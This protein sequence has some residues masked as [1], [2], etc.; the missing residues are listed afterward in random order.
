M[1]PVLK[2]SQVGGQA[3]RDPQGSPEHR[4]SEQSD[5]PSLPTAVRQV[6]GQSGL[7]SRAMN[8]G[9]MPARLELTT[10]GAGA[11]SNHPQVKQGYVIQDNGGL[12]INMAQGDQDLVWD[13]DLDSNGSTTSTP[14]YK[15]GR[16]DSVTSHDAVMALQR[17]ASKFVWNS[18]VTPSIQVLAD[19]RLSHW[20]ADR[21]CIIE[22]KLWDFKKWLSAIRAEIICIQC[23]T[24]VLYMEK[25]QMFTEVTPLKNGM[26]AICRAIRQHN[27]STRIFISNILPKSSISPIKRVESN[28]ILLQ[29]VRSVNRCIGKVHYLSMYEHF[30]SRKG[31]LITP[32]HKYLDLDE[33][34]TTLG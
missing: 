12:L 31:R 6:E 23:N 13:S 14:S 28:F 9:G 5:M 10:P 16:H 34:L 20:P 17:E 15:R 18:T 4:L 7:T 26:Q 21:S 22:Y 30:I 8:T 33:E 29:A 1:Q 27:R 32:T 11:K 24:V 19:S 2:Y 3:V 25:T